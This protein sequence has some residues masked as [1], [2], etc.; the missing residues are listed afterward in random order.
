MISRFLSV[1]AVAALLVTALPA[2]ADTPA[3][4][5]QDAW[6]KIDSY[7]ATITT[8]ETNGKEAQDRV[9]HYAYKKPH[10]AKIDIVAGPGRGG[11]A[12]WSGGDKVKGHQ[13]GFLSGIKLSV[14]ISDGR[15]ASLRG[16]TIDHGS[17]QS[18]ADE[19]KSG[20]VDS[21]TTLATIDGAAAD[22]VTVIAP[23]TTVG[24]VTKYV[25][26]FSR[27]THMPVRRT[28]FSGD[29]LVKQEDFSDVKVN[30]GLT[31]N[32]FN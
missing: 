9:Y 27:A 11:G 20:K 17:F 2:G 1:G 13:G 22:A 8:H 7:T 15:A 5:F 25:L 19:L 29:A 24:G 10:F 16:D 28:A 14:G 3:A 26:F 23:A 6:A 18:I 21:A 4:E 31:E 32:D 12:V 30:A